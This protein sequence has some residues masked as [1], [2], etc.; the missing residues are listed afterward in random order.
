[1]ARAQGFTGEGPVHSAEE[2]RSAFERGAAIVES[3]GCHL[4][5]ARIEPGY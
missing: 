3:G 1:M 5:D 4:I 2:L